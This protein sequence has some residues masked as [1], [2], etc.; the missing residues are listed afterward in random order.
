VVSDRIASRAEKVLLSRKDVAKLV[1][2][3]R[4]RSSEL[5]EPG[6]YLRSN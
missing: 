6:N 2:Y 5:N 4:R 1:G 3:A